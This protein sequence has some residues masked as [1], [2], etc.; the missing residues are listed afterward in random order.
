M[1]SDGE[2]RV[3]ALASRVHAHPGLMASGRYSSSRYFWPSRVQP[4]C[5]VLVD[6]TDDVLEDHGDPFSHA[7]KM[8]DD[9]LSSRLLPPSRPLPPR[10]LLSL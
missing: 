5:L 2:R 4:L 3:S 7:H 6:L 1:V 10:R 9:N 8:K